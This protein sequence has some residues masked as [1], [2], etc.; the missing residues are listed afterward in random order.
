MDGLDE[1][2]RHMSS[3]CMPRVR[4]L[5]VCML[6]LACLVACDPDKKDAKA[7]PQIALTIAGAT[8]NV[9]V[10]QRPEDQQRGLMFRDS[11][12][13]DHG[14]IFVFG[15]PRQ[16]SFWMRN[17]R[18]PLSIAYIDGRGVILEIHDMRPF[19]D[20]A[21]RS[22]SSEVCYAIE[23]NL[24]WFTRQGISAGDRVIGLEALQKLPL[25]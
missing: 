3:P 19:D 10:A 2:V 4:T 1:R 15:E 6:M 20:A 25:H 18:I 13:A 11:L 8:L 7:L 17:T 16:A 23:A 5:A 24:G 9:E 21:I 22:R 14:M 12:A